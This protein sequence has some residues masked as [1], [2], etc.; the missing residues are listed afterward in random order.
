[1]TTS[2]R[3]TITWNRVRLE[4]LRAAYNQAIEKRTRVFRVALTDEG[5]HDFEIG[6]A[7]QTLAWLDIEF[8]TPEIPRQPNNEGEEGQ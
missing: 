7:K 5:T 2:I 8:R 3:K 6:Y 1:M 4:E